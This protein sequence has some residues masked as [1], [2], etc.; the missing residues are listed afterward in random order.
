METGRL[1]CNRERVA[2]SQRVR[3]ARM[4]RIDYMPG[5]EAVAILERVRLQRIPG[6]QGATNSAILDDVLLDWSR[7]SAGAGLPQKPT[8]KVERNRPAAPM[9]ALVRQTVA[10]AQCGAVRHRDGNP[11]QARP[12]PGKKRCRFHGGRSTGPRTP[13]GKARCAANL[14]NRRKEGQ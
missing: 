10:K 4:V 7:L 1:S 14:P 3:R 12:E 2:R 6:S 9:P 5:K 11:C 13:E 8:S